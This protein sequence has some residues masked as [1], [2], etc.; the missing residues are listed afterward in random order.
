M[1]IKILV[2]ALIS[3][4]FV[5]LSWRALRN[6]SPY[7]LYRFFA[8]ETLTGL[9]LVNVDHWF[10][11]PF[12]PSHLLS[13]FLL[14][15]SLPLA[16]HG[17]W[18]LRTIGQPQGNIEDTT[19]L[20]VRGAYRYIRHPLY[21]SL[22]MFAWG[23]FFKAISLAAGLLLALVCVFLTATARLEE[24]RNLVRFGMAYEDYRKRTKM[25]IPFIF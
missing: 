24:R 14:I 1:T 5:R 19:E 11:D 4:G 13:W 2:F 7:G 3:I 8:F 12:S 25:F 16:I 20:V 15:G 22:M 10:T 6:R 21:A 9:F 18:M 23:V 17:F